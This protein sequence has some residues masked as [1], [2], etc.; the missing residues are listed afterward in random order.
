MEVGDTIY[1][2]I[3][4]FK[5]SGEGYNIPWVNNPV[6]ANGYSSSIGIICWRV[7]LTYI[8]CVSD[9]FSSIHRYVFIMNDTEVGSTRYTLFL[10]AFI[11]CTNTLVYTSN[12]IAVVFFPNMLVFGIAAELAV[13][14]GL[15]RLSV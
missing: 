12:F 14:K 9:L 7:Y 5:G 2:G 15:T 10:G 4:N 8:I 6:A 1:Y 3:E 13:F 11:S